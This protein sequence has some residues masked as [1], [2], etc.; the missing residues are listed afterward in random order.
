MVK[1]E[2]ENRLNVLFSKGNSFKFKNYAS[3]EM[4]ERQNY[5]KIM[6]EI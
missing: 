4:T 6:F 3:V 5:L 1:E 2:T